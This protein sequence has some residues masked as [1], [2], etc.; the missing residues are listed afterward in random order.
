[1]EPSL[2]PPPRRAAVPRAKAAPK[3]TAKPM[4]AR[5]Q[6]ARLPWTELRLQW[7]FAAAHAFLE[8]LALFKNQDNQSL[9]LWS[10]CVVP[11][12]SMHLHCALPVF[13][14][15]SHSQCSPMLDCFELF[16]IRIVQ[17][18]RQGAHEPVVYTTTSLLGAHTDTTAS[19]SWREGGEELQQSGCAGNV[20]WKPLY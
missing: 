19:L 9:Y 15:C 8:G 11:V 17:I 10:S 2:P 14:L 5:R 13:S 3:P 16:P 20:L 6:R 1:M 7:F 4:T 12:F 18:A